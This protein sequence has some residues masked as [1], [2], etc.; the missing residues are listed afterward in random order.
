MKAVNTKTLKVLIDTN[1]WIDYYTGRDGAQGCSSKLIK[2]LLCS[3]HDVYVSA[4]STKDVF[5]LLQAYLKLA[6]RKQD[7]D[8]FSLEQVRAIQEVAWKCTEHLIKTAKLAAV[9]TA[10]CER[11]LALREFGNDYEDNL[12]VACA[13]ACGADYLVTNDE[14]LKAP[15]TIAIV[16]PQELYSMLFED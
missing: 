2:S 9:G 15:G 14:S 4:L 3:K 8:T 13:E 6:H 7:G 1:T 10:E 5:Y 11:A 12:I 16:S